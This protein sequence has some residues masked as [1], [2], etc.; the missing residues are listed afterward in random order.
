MA[1]QPI[2]R[3]NVSELVFNQMREMIVSGEWAP[4]SKIS[5]ENELANQMGVS[6][7]TI[8]SA[9]QK[10]SS[11]GLV[12]SRH[13]EG[14][15][16]CKLDGTQCF[17]SMLPMIVLSKVNRESLHEFRTIIE[18]ACALLAAQRITPEQLAEIRAANEHMAE[19][20]DNPEAAAAF[21][22]AFH[23]GIANATGNPYIIQV[24]DIL[25]TIFTRSLVENIHHMGASSGVH[26]HSQITEAL[27]L[28]DGALAQKRMEDHL[29][30]THE[31]MVRLLEKQA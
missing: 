16:V 8:R 10:L 12:E 4:G 2:K 24:F 20:K 29:K 27:E 6:R 28:H 7:V 9:I 14:T 30:V 22:M 5:S 25:E 15:Y 19:N 11:L 13:G 17:N 23:K 31:T 3:Q 21:D 1:I 18:S 26:F